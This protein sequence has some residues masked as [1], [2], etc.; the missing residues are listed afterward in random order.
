MV[1]TNL[2]YDVPMPEVGDTAMLT[3]VVERVERM[4]GATV[5]LLNEYFARRQPGDT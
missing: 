2:G 1:S 4:A 3:D 5:P